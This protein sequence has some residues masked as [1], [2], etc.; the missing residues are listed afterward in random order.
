MKHLRL[1]GPFAIE[2]AIQR[3]L[4]A[5]AVMGRKA[6]NWTS[7]ATFQISLGR[8]DGIITT[9]AR[10][11]HPDGQALHGRRQG[12]NNLQGH[13]NA[14]EPLAVLLAQ[15]SPALLIEIKSLTNLS[16]DM[17]QGSSEARDP[18]IRS[19]IASAIA[20]LRSTCGNDVIA[21][22]MRSNAPI[23]VD[24]ACD[25]YLSISLGGAQAAGGAGDTV[26]KRTLKLLA[27]L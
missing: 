8:L 18:Q 4:T 11:G 5:H 21:H 7:D 20:D 10:L 6:V 15:N 24:S 9:A 27:H 2:S 3:H 12:V 26:V 16:N 22:E 13:A 23:T 14:L 17:G 1:A 19:I 25:T